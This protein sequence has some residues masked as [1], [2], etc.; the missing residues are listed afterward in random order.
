LKVSAEYRNSSI[1][2]GVSSRAKVSSLGARV[3]AR[4]GRSGRRRV[5]VHDVVLFLDRQAAR[6]ADRMPHRD[7]DQRA[8]LA[9]LAAHVGDARDAL[10]LVADAK[11]AVEDEPPAGPHAPL[12]R[13]RRKEAAAARM[14]VGPQLALRRERQEVKPMPERRDARAGRGFGEKV[15]AVERRGQ[16]GDRHRRGDVAA[17]FAAADPAAQ[18]LEVQGRDRFVGHT[19]AWRLAARKTIQ[20]IPAQRR[21]ACGGARIA[22][23]LPAPVQCATRGWRAL[24]ADRGAFAGSPRFPSTRSLDAKETGMKAGKLW[25][26]LAAL[27]AVLAAPAAAQQLYVFTSGSLGGFPKAALQAGAQGNLDWVP[28]S[29]YVLKH[30]KGNVM[31]DCGNNDKT[32]TD[33]AG[34]W[35]PLAKGF[36]IKMTADDAIPAQLA[37][38]GLKTSDIKYLVVGHMHLDHGGNIGQFP[39]A[40]L[41]VQ[42]DELKAAQS[43]DPGFSVYYIPGDFAEV[44]NMNVLRLAGDFDLFGDGSFR[45]FSARGHTQG[46]QFAVVKLPK[47]GSVILTSDVVYLKENLDKNLIPPVPGVTHPIDAYKS[48]SKIRFIRDSENA[49]IFYGHDPE[50]FKATKHAPEYYE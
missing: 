44:K 22:H 49:Q 19:Q 26:A 25:T 13:H 8:A 32:I 15:V 30:P 31:F 24:A 7:E 33:A 48:Y 50:V 20:T 16:R 46:S 10:D 21:R 23:R 34:W 18:A 14:A 39:N 45:I 47:T 38:I 36:G 6:A 43:P 4:R 29:F 41:I 5:A 3:G 9:G 11:R 37:K 42:D 35:G 17:R 2:S 28:V 12:Q 27:S 40:T 1:G